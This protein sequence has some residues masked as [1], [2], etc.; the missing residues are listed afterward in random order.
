MGT[1]KALTMNM[2]KDFFSVEFPDHGE[3][4]RELEIWK[5]ECYRKLQ[6]TYP[7]ISFSFSDI[8]EKSYPQVRRKI[9]ETVVDLYNY[10]DFLSE[11]DLLNS[12]EKEYFA[13]ISSDMEDAE[14]SISLRRLSGYLQRYYGKKV[15]ILLDEYDTPMLEAY[16]T[17]YG[18]TVSHSA[19]KKS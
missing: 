16:K 9:C 15:I 12:R 18:S 5:E 8:K 19:E 3:L 6:G 7:V 14:I 4:F 10:F 13:G 1:V 17:G 11:G 2:L